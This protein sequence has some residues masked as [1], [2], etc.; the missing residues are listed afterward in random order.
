MSAI[1]IFNCTQSS[2]LFLCRYANTYTQYERCFHSIQSRSSYVTT[3]SVTVHCLSV[4]LFKRSRNMK[5][6]DWLSTLI[7][8][9]QLRRR[10]NTSLTIYVDAVNVIRRRAF[11]QVHSH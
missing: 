8:A 4:K 3:V 1:L 2:L 5:L 10:T 6:N 7:I 11:S 9:G